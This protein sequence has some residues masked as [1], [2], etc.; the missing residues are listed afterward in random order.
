MKITI[1]ILLTVTF[2]NAQAATDE[3]LNSIY[4]EAILFVAVFGVMGIVSF[5][6]SRRHA[7]AYVAPKVVVELTSHQLA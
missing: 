2:L 6:Y 5:I 4:A 7:K 1:F 3:Q